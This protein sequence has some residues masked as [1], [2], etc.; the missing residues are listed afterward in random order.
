MAV[1]WDSRPISI[2]AAAEGRSVLL[3]VKLALILNLSNFSLEFDCLQVINALILTRMRCLNMEVSLMII[4]I[5][6]VE[7]EVIVYF[8]HVRSAG[9]ALAHTLA[10]VA[11]RL[12]SSCACAGNFP[13]C[14]H[15]AR[16]ADIP[17]L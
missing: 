10:R 13:L 17:Y 14:V 15:S 5:S 16:D 6:F 11:L 12:I 1:D 4:K 7:V 8:S 9:N 2:T 3:G